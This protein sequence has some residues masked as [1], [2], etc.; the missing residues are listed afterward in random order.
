V[1]EGKFKIMWKENYFY[2]EFG[3]SVILIVSAEVEQ[4]LYVFGYSELVRKC[5]VDLTH[6]H[7][8]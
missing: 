7:P 8:P 1:R 4:R 5:P 6:L 2:V 3:A